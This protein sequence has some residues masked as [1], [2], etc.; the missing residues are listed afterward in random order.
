M[1]R[2]LFARLSLQLSVLLYAGIALCMPIV[3]TADITVTDDR[4]RQI[5]L[6][7]RPERIIALAPFVAELLFAAGAGQKII[8][9]ARYTD[10]PPEAASLPQIGDASRID[11][12][13]R[14]H[15]GE[16]G[17]ETH[18]NTSDSSVANSIAPQTHTAWSG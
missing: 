11:V 15:H 8:G 3:A 9:V 14:E 10:F 6:S 18:G 16:F 17:T 5:A 7:A 13:T 4:G 12:E 1:R 2:R